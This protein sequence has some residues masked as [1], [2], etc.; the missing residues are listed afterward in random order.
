[1]LHSFLLSGLLSHIN[2]K[3]KIIVI[4]SDNIKIYHEHTKF[5]ED[6]VF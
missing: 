5:R 3:E 1:M 2:S 6:Q 4:S